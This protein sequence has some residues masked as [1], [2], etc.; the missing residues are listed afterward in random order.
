MTERKTFV[1]FFQTAIL[2]ILLAFCVI[3]ST[4]NFSYAA[5]DGAKLFFACVFPAMFPYSFLV[6]LTSS[7]S[8]TPIISLKFSP[9]TKR[10]FNT[11]G[12]T[13]YALFISL[14]SGYPM[15]SKIVSDLRK[16]RLIGEEEAARAA[17][18]CS[19]PSPAFLIGGIGAV[20]FGSAA[21]GAYIYLCNILSNF[22]CGFI[23]S[24]YKR[25]VRPT[26]RTENPTSKKT[27]N[28][29]YNGAYSAAISSL[30][31]GALIV[32]FYILSEIIFSFSVTKFFVSFLG[33]K[34][35]YFNAS[36]ILKGILECTNGLKTLSTGGISFFTLPIAAALSGFGG[37]SVLCQSA[38]FIKSA[39]IKIAPFF[40]S[41]IIGAI[42]SFFF[43]II[44]SFLL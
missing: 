30:I 36:G 4:G 44:F 9:L 38:A 1:Y 25:K 33:E 34:I 16:N 6:T 32:I 11:G 3:I 29:L 13:A 37:L 40:L 12:I 39:K 15:G 20:T 10:I 7:L 35:G 22:I 5:V 14:I 31:V 18:F 43:G 26:I 21:F 27:E 23:F 28:I 8:V 2:L 19:T 42:L 17:T 24:S 41:K